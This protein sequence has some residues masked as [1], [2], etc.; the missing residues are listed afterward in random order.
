MNKRKQKLTIEEKCKILQALKDGTQIKAICMQ[1]NVNKSTI[2]PIKNNNENR[3]NF[4]KK[5]FPSK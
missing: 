5:V 4:A 3:Q 1:Y 2:T